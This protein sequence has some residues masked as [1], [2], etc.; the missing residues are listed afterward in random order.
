M[1]ENCVRTPI[2]LVFLFP[3]KKKAGE[4][5]GKVGTRHEKNKE[6][7]IEKAI[8]SRFSRKKARRKER[9]KAGGIAGV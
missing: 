4:N 5:R 9:K 1:S 7:K 3:V 8:K 6:K 2:S